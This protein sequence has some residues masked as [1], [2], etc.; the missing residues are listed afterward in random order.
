MRR[1]LSYVISDYLRTWQELEGKVQHCAKSNDLW[2]IE[3]AAISTNSDTIYYLP[4]ANNSLRGV[5]VRVGIGT[6]IS[7][8]HQLKKVFA[9][10]TEFFGADPMFKT[11]ADLFS[12]VG[13][14]FPF[15]VGSQS[16]INRAVIRI[17]RDNYARQNVIQIG[18]STFL[19]NLVKRN[20]VDLLIIEGE[21]GEYNMLQELSMEGSVTERGVTVCQINIEFHRPTRPGDPREQ[22]FLD[23]L[24]LLAREGRYVILS[25]HNIGH[26]RIFLVNFDS[27]LCRSR[28]IEHFYS[29]TL[30]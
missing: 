1:E 16:S 2:H 21:G 8:E 3:T 10:G 28:Y 18:L 11:N 13:V 23:I 7:I 5:I 24:D 14:Y 6:N 4:P 22:K 30:S 20:V 12:S 19:G 26:Y 15:A 9:Q 27:E 17:S 29:N 25:A